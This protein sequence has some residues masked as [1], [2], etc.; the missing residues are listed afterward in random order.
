MKPL[1][2]TGIALMIIGAVLLG[3]YSYT[4]QE[5]V[6]KLGPIEATAEKQHTLSVPPPVGWTLL[7]AGVAV[8]IVGAT[9][10]GRN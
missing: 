1:L 8:L 6:F 9:R 2:A 5:S 7:V 10:K 3:H 4:T